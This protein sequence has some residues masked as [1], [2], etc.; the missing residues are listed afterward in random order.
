MILRISGKIT[1]QDVDLLRA[2]PEQETRALVLDLKDLL[3]ADREAVK[4]LALREFGPNNIL[5]HEGA[6]WEV[7]SFQSPPGGL[8]ERR[9]QKRFC[10]VCGTFTDTSLDRCPNCDSRFDPTNSELLTLLDQPNVRC[11]RRERITCDAG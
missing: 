4:L 11:R 9:S 6:K 8:E 10:G 5:Y 7:V 2:L 3:L 1:G